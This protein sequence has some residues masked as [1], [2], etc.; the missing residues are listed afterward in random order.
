VKAWTREQN[1]LIKE[2]VFLPYPLDTN[3]NLIL[4]DNPVIFPLMDLYEYRLER[5]RIVANGAQDDRTKKKTC[6]LTQNRDVLFY[7]LSVNESMNGWR[8]HTSLPQCPFS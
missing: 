4:P 7:M 3:D 2:Q 6:A 5:V 1:K 8:C